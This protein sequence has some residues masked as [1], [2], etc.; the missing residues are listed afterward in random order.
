MK[1]RSISVALVG[2]GYMATE[3]A[4]AFSSLPG[5]NVVG[6]CG[7]DQARAQALADGYGATVFDD[8][9]TMYRET[10]AEIVVVAVNE[11]SMLDVC[12]AVFKHSWIC[13]LE[14][15]VGLNIEEAETIFQAAQKAKV[16][17]FVAL[18]RRAYSSTRQAK[19]ELQSCDSPRLV[20]VLDQQDLNSV[21]ASG[22]PMEVVRN[23]MYANSIHVIDYFNQFCRGL[24]V[25]L[26][27]QKAW[28]PENPSHV[29]AT[30]RYDSGDFGVYQAVW[31]RPGP[32][33]VAITNSQVRLELRP[34]EKLSI[35]RL[36]E[37]HSLD[38]PLE[39]VDLNFKPGLFWQAKQVVAALSESHSNLVTLKT[40]LLSMD[41]V[42]QLYGLKKHKLKL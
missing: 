41:L 35:Q 15:P 39:E 34:L 32:W 1:T 42:A 40:A 24:L 25:E 8:V 17:V 11:M 20:S 23:Y 21:I 28:N 16:R 2:A 6:V 9:A 26:E 7:R 33:S 27:I 12:E 30:I 4:R 38:V 29:I 37:R 10:A 22:Q 3:H 13:L 31:D 14:K 19:I 36:G 5:V 18:N